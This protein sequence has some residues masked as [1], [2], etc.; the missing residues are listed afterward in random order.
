ME[1]KANWKRIAFILFGH[2]HLLPFSL[3]CYI[4]Y[5]IPMLILGG[6]KWDGWADFAIPRFKVPEGGGT[7]THLGLWG[8]WYGLAIPVAIIKRWDAGE[9][10]EPH[11]MTHIDQIMTFGALGMLAYVAHSVYIWLFRKDRHAYYDNIFE[12]EARHNAG[13]PTFIP[14]TR[15]KDPKDRWPWW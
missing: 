7:D 1:K 13:Q 6:L 4:F 12:V 14:Q 10:T 11:E 9:K 3:L 2:L 15:W 8:S 5:V